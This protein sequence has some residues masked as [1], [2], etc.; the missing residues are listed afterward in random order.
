MCWRRVHVR[1]YCHYSIKVSTRVYWCDDL[2]SFA[3]SKALHET[4]EGVD[5][6]R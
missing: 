1:V 6:D 2:I 5:R 3:S 4:K